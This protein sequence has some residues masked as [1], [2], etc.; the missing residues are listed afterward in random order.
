MKPVYCVRIDVPEW[1]VEQRATVRRLVAD[2][3]ESE[4]P[5]SEREAGISVRLDDDDPDRWWRATVDRTVGQGATTSTSVTLTTVDKHTTFEV[6]VVHTPGG[7]RV[8]PLRNPVSLKAVR[9]LTHRV[10]SACTVY[11]ANMRVRSEASVITDPAGSEMMAALCEA[12]GRVLPVVIETVPSHA[13]PVFAVERLAVSL[14]GLAHVVQLTGDAARSAFNS[15]HGSSILGAQS[16]TVVWPDGGHQS[17]DGS[18]LAPSGGE[19]VR[20]EMISLITTTAAESLA[21]VRPPLFRVRRTVDDTTEPDVAREQVGRE[22]RAREHGGSG[23]DPETVAWSDYRAA[24]DEWQESVARVDELEV[25]LTE[26]DRVIAEKQELLD[27]GDVLLDHLVLQNTELAIRLGRNPSGLVATSAVDAVKQAE[28]MCEYL[29]FHERAFQTARDLDGIDANRLLQDL[30]RLNIVAGDWQA[31]RINRASLTISCRSLGLNYAAGV[32][33][34]AEY[35]FGSDYAFTWRGRTEYAVAHIRNGRGSRLYR[36]H[37]FF[38]DETH[39]VVVVH[40][41]RHLRDKSSN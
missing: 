31:G 41:G 2:W 4:F 18:R 33:D 6:R 24:L 35:K 32:S 39:Q 20:A 15:F 26:A 34:T 29:T 11:D 37:V 25:A 30:V 23:D 3:L 21:P 28:Q 27:K 5:F 38:D 8:S 14:S 13:R 22:D 19:K 9:V 10:V 12:P 40:V 36:V 16:L 7:R 1:S 17:Y